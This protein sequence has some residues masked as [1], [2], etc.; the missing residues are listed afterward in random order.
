MKQFVVCSFCTRGIYEGIYDSHLGESL[1]MFPEI[2]WYHEYIQSQGNWYKNTCYKPFFLIDCLDKFP[3]KNIILLDVDAKII[4]YPKLFET[5]PDKFNFGCYILNQNEYYRNGSNRVE[6]LTGT[7]FI[8]NTIQSRFFVKEWIIRTGN[9]TD[10]DSFDQMINGY[11]P[12]I[13]SLPIEYCR[14]TSLPNGNEPNIS[15][16]EPVIEHYAASRNL[17]HLKI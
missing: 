17:K 15:C 7:L 12:N 6:H 8:S 10:Q 3:D 9:G 1:K 11:K 4:K 14:I 2:K 13:F 5:I 16:Q